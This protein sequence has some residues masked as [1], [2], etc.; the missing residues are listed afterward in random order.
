MFCSN[1]YCAQYVPCSKHENEFEFEVESCNTIW[2][3]FTSLTFEC[4]KSKHSDAWFGGC[5]H[6]RQWQPS[7]DAF[8]FT[9]STIQ[10]SEES[11]YWHDEMECS[12]CFTFIED[13]NDL[14]LNLSDMCQ[15]H[16][17]CIQRMLQTKIFDKC[18]GCNEDRC[19]ACYHCSY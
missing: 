3:G 17:R 2:S 11:G 13:A 7:Q 16:Y 9:S 14:V 18:P 12:I 4:D 10:L 8:T 15:F 5:S 6:F 19:R 1:D